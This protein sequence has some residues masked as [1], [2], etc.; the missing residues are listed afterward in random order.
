LDFDFELRAAEAVNGK[1]FDEVW[2]NFR[3]LK[4]TKQF[5]LIEKGQTNSIRKPIINIYKKNLS[6]QKRLE[7]D[8]KLAGFAIK[9]NLYPIYQ[10]LFGKEY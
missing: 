6:F 4:G 5:T 9:R 1:Y 10:K 8:L 3:L 2:G 7:L